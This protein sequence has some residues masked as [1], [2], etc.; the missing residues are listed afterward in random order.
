MICRRVAASMVSLPGLTFRRTACVGRGGSTSLTDATSKAGPTRVC[1]VG[2][3]AN[4]PTTATIPTAPRRD[5]TVADYSLGR[6]A[7]AIAFSFVSYSSA[8]FVPPETRIVTAAPP[9]LMF[10]VVSVVRPCVNVE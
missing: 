2:T 3:P 1:A 4:P 10:S 7:R 5:F 8:G 9:F 6:R